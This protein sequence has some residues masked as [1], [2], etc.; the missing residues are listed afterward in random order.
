MLVGVLGLGRMGRPIATALVGALRQRGY[1]V[2]TGVVNAADYGVP[3]KRIRAL[4]AATRCVEQVSK[5][6]RLR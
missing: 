5:A 3:Q 2:R 1:L 6:A 4:V